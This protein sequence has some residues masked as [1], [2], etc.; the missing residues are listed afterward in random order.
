MSRIHV[1]VAVLLPLMLFLWWTFP[2]LGWLWLFFGFV[3]LGY[4]VYVQQWVWSL[5]ICLAFSLPLS[6]ELSLVNNH[7]WFFP[8]EALLAVLAIALVF[9]MRKERLKTYDVWPLYWLFAFAPGVLFSEYPIMSLKF[10]VV[11]AAYVFVFYYGIQFLIKNGNAIKPLFQVY[12]IALVPVLLWAIWQFV[13]YELNPVT[14]PGIFKPFYNDHTVTGAVL[15][16][17]AG[18]F[19]ASGAT[20]KRYYFLSALIILFVVMTGSRAALLSVAIML[21]VYVAITFAWMRR[22]APFALVLMAFFV[23]TKRDVVTDFMTHNTS[24]S[25]EEALSERVKSSANVNTDASNIERLN[26]WS[27]AWN[28]FLERPHT[29]FGPGTYRFTYLPFQD[30]RYENRLTVKNPDHPPHGSGGTAH[31]EIFLQLSE[32]GWLPTFVF[33]V[34]LGRWVFYG[35]RQ[36]VNGHLAAIA[37]LLGLSTYLF[38]MNVNNFLTTDAFA[39]LFWGSAAAIMI[40]VKQ[41]ANE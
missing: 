13:G 16:V 5:F 12:S 8:S 31:S 36:A 39:F 1:I 23:Y 29:G 28:M 38:H 10:M 22:F 18:Y 40:S 17:L 19:F 3:M 30:K 33:L 35:W 2:S 9:S 27:S 32:A 37:G 7:K 41:Q 26:R 11:N 25:R 15:A 4:V 14:L 24:G 6:V 34:M 20:D 21:M